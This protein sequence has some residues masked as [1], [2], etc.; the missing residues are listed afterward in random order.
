VAHLGLL[1]AAA[2]ALVTLQFLHVQTAIH[3]G[4]GLAFVALVAIHLAQRRHTVARMLVQ[5]WR[6]PWPGERR[7]ALAVSDLLLWFITLNVL[8]S[9]ALDWARG[10]ALL[11][12]LPQPLARWHGLSGIVLVLYLVVHVWHRRRRLRRSSIR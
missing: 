7:A 3:T 8:V 9:G 11:L 1:V 2:A 6:A 5:L 12:P 10:R 4:A